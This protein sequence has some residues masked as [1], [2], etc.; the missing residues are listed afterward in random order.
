[1]V[2]LSYSALFCDAV[3]RRASLH[4]RGEG[5]GARLCDKLVVVA[6]HLEE[7]GVDLVVAVWV[8]AAKKCQG[9]PLR[10]NLI[11][12]PVLVVGKAEGEG[13]DALQHG[14]AGVR[15]PHLESVDIVVQLLH[16]SAPNDGK[17]IRV[18]L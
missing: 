16:R 17:H 10:R 7:P 12:S 9:R 1:M 11:H 8:R 14:N 6:R 13:H 18:L 15:E 2:K 4:E 5:D 3:C